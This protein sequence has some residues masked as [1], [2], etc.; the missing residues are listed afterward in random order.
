MVW[1]TVMRGLRELKGSWKMI[2]KF[3]RR[4]RRAALLRGTMSSPRMEDAARGRLDEAQEKAARGRLAAAGFADETEGLTL[5][6]S[7]GQCRRL[8]APRLRCAWTGGGARDSKTLV[9]PLA[10]TRGDGAATAFMSPSPAGHSVAGRLEAGG[11]MI[12]ARSDGA[13]GAPSC[14]RPAARGSD[15]RSGNRTG[16]RRRPAPTPSIE[17]RRPR[18]P[19]VLRDRGQE[20]ARIGMR[21]RVEEPAHR[22]DLGHAAGIEH[23]HPIGAFAQSRRDRG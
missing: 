5:S 4:A 10:S 16:D 6:G 18:G 22:C 12:L 3:R 9:S 23:E 20:G 14:R 17:A 11:P 2:W 19:L 1:P 21:R 8:R 15:R 13:G 7:T